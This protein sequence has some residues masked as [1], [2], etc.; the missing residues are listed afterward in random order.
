MTKFQKAFYRIGQASAFVLVVAFWW[1]ALLEMDYVGWPKF[2][3]P[4][5]GRIIPYE[6]KNILVYISPKD[7]EFGRTLKWTMIVSGSLM[8]VCLVFSGELGKMLNP[9]KPPLPPL[10]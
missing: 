3:Q 2:P 7:A 4:E 6:V 8:A 9:P 5:I 1:W 10:I